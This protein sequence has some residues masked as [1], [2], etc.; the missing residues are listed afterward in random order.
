MADLD[1]QFALTFYG[2]D[3][4]GVD[5]V[6]VGAGY[7]ESIGTMDQD[8]EHRV[9]NPLCGLIV[10]E[11]AHCVSRAKRPSPLV[12][13][14]GDVQDAQLPAILLSFGPHVPRGEPNTG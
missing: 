5:I 6:R 3:T 8:A 4:H 1:H 14:H 2:P 7:V 10:D 12:A 11:H 13:H 9:L